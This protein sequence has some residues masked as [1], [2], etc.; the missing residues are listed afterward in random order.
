VD[1][2][3]ATLGLSATPASFAPGGSGAAGTTRLSWTASERVDGWLRLMRGSTLVRRWAVSGTSGAVTWDGRDTAGRLVADGRYSLQLPVNDWY[4]NA[5]SRSMWLYADRTLRSF[6]ASPSAFFPQD[7]DALARTTAFTAVTARSATLTLRVLD[8]EGAE[9]RRA[10][11]NRS[12]A[13]GSHTWRWDGTVTGGGWAPRGPYTAVLTGLTQYG[14]MELSRS[15]VA[16]AF[17]WQLSSSRPR[18]GA[19]FAVI[20]RSAEPLRE[21]PR[22]TI[23][24]STGTPLSLTVVRRSD[25]SWRGT[26]TLPPAWSGPATLT[27]SGRDTGG[28]SNSSTV[29][30]AIGA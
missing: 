28:R 22:A 5:S 14:T 26:A 27:L 16:D 29:D 12:V 9:V 6:T 19:A 10:W 2:T 1:T 25:G 24:A 4:G 8:A 20:F 17:T 21:T 30:L 11:T 23:T 15:I 7:G 13:A 3:P 18:A